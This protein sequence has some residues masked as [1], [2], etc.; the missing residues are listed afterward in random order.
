MPCLL[1]A[2]DYVYSLTADTGP[3][4]RYTLAGHIDATKS[5]P[6]VIPANTE[7]PAQIRSRPYWLLDQREAILTSHRIQDE[8]VRSG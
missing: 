8:C 7:T 2:K 4:T 5:R 6:Y 1:F 3:L